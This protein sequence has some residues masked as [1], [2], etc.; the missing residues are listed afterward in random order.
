[1][2]SVRWDFIFQEMKTFGPKSFKNIQKREDELVNQTAE[3][4]AAAR[5]D[6]GMKTELQDCI[7]SWGPQLR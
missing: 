3:F 2:F 7:N 6:E 4:L 1:M 5:L